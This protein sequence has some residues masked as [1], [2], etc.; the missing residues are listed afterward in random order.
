MI[1][2]NDFLKHEHIARL[3]QVCTAVGVAFVKTSTGYGFV[4]QESGQYDYVGATVPHVR[5]MKESCGEGVKIKAAGGVRSLDE[6]LYM[7]H[8]GVS[9]IGTTGTVAIL[10]AARKRGIGD[11]PVAVK[12][13][14]PADRAG[15]HHGDGY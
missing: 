2:E 1:F 6:F 5:L 13:V 15:D 8:L 10:E 4:K 3:C 9:R 11:E 7:M 12:L 14:D